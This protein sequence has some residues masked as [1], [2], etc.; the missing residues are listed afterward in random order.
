MTKQTKPHYHSPYFKQFKY[1]LSQVGLVNQFDR[2]MYSNEDKIW[3]KN[4]AY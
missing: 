3:F 2:Q 1:Y 4:Q